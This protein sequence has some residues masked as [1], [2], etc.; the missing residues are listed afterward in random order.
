MGSEQY[1]QTYWAPYIKTA[2]ICTNYKQCGYKKVNP[3]VFAN[4]EEHLTAVAVPGRRVTFYTPDG[5]LYAIFTAVG[6]SSSATGEVENHSVIVD[7]NGPEGPNKMGRDVFYL[8]R[9]EKDGAGIQT[10][11]MDRSDKF[12]N[13]ECSA[14]G[15]GYYCAERIRRA[16]WEIDKTYPW[17]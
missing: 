11:G 1:F 3:W 4:N 2:L 14:T 7:L 12:I 17:K 16:G 10:L 9:V 15:S 5:F 6:N 8:A 13:Q